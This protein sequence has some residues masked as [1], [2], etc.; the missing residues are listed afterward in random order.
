MGE[1]GFEIMPQ[2]E[3]EKPPHYKFMIT[4]H[5][6]R[7][8]DGQ[9]TEEGVEHAKRKGQFVGDAEV[10]KAY[11]SDHPSGRALKTG[12]LISRESGIKSPATGE[13]YATREVSGI[14]YDI[15]EP[16]LYHIIPE[17]KNLIEEATL[18]E[19]GMS[20]ERD[21]K[22][23]LKINIEKLPVE[24]Q[25]K[26][27]PV[28]QKYQKLGFEYLLSNKDGVHR[29][30][31]GL[32]HQLV[33]EF[34]I[35]KRYDNGRKIANDP[36]EKDV[37]I[38]T[39]THGMFMESILKEAGIMVKEDGSDERGVTDFESERF[40]GYIQ[41]AE[42][43]YLDVEDPA[44]MPEKIPVIFEGENRPKPGV[45]FIDRKKLENLNNDYVEWKR[46]L[47]SEKQIED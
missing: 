42:S 31:I 43:I 25:L 9:L 40:G 39:A 33:R 37:V 18:K 16:D 38:N 36:P 45:I 35:A 11:G 41:P 20:T 28:R 13:P 3:E 14:Q 1:K 5:A 19:L 29:L 34:E 7:R 26:I 8:P 30:A 10:L 15:L 46:S 24:E 4:R 32:A 6:E 17:A 47:E 44:K 12:D 2:A 21:E 27:A 22:G 23:R